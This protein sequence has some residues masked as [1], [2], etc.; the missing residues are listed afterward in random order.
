MRLQI[1]GAEPIACPLIAIAPPDDLM[2]L[3]T[4]IQQITTYDWLIVTSANAVH[5]F[6][7]RLIAAGY[8]PESLAHL[9]I[10]ASGPATAEALAQH[11]LHA[12]FV[13]S[14]YLA[15]TILAEIGDIAGN[16]ILLPH[17]DLA[18][19][20]LAAGLRAQGATVDAVIAYRTI[21]G[22]GIP[23][24]ITHLLAGTVD[25]ITFTSSSTVRY[26][27]DGLKKAGIVPTKIHTLLARPAIICIGPQTAATAR[28]LGLR[29][30]SIAAEYTTEG[31]IAA[32]LAYF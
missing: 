20:T 19:E 3:N 26:L 10:G 5:A 7:E 29:V 18:R 2:P 31:L 25:A 11:G 21:P 13:P 30:D 6:F 9:K 4:A 15:E 23:K 32:L 28:K 27:L 1:L 12:T 16:R 17:A 14:T 22:P 8:S 24:L